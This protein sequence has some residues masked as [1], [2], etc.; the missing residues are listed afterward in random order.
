MRKKKGKK[1][2]ATSSRVVHF[3]KIIGI[4]WDPINHKIF[5]PSLAR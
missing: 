3:H 2:E 5:L 1:E 4:R